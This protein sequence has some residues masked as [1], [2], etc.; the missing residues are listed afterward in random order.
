MKYSILSKKFTDYNEYI[1]DILNL[2]ENLLIL[3]SL[4]GNIMSS[5]SL[6]NK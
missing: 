2:L 6:F 3:I 1:E 4:L 5:F